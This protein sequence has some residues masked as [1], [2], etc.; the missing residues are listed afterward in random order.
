MRAEWWTGVRDTAVEVACNGEAHVVRWRAGRLETVDHTDADAEAALG[1]LGGRPP[2]CVDLLGRWRRQADAVELVSLWRRPGEDLEGFAADQV[3]PLIAAASHRG[4]T[5]DDQRRG[6]LLALLSLPGPMIDRLVLGVLASAS[7]RW[8]D[9]T[10]RERH[11]LRLGAALA[12]RAEPAIVRFACELV[13]PGHAS[14]TASPA[15]PG[16]P[17][18]VAARVASQDHLVVDAFISLT[19][20]G[21]VWARGVSE[22]DGRLV[23]AVRGVDGAGDRLDVDVATWQ[24]ARGGGWSCEPER[25]VIERRPDGG[26][27]L[28]R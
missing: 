14:V 27:R 1:A 19:W 15:R 25:A 24:E 10:F 13:P 22:V 26:W 4:A 12:A 23:L 8:H 18:R 17:T 21:E 3:R 28:A 2:P 5:A 20:L 16:E 6:D 11:G 9:D 7:E